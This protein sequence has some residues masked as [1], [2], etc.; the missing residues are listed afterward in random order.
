MSPSRPDP[1]ARRRRR[2]AGR[3]SAHRPPLPL[4]LLDVGQPVAGDGA[5]AQGVAHRAGDGLR[6]RQGERDD[7]RHA[8]RPRL[9]RGRAAAGPPRGFHRRRGGHAPSSPPRRS[10]ST[11][12]SGAS[13]SSEHTEIGELRFNVFELVE[14]LRG[15]GIAHALAHPFSLVAGGLRGE[16]LE[17]L[18]SLFDV[19]E[20]RNGLSCREEDELAEDVVA[21]SAGLRARIGG[22]AGSPQPADRRLRRLQ[23]PHW[24][25]RRHDLHRHPARAGRRDASGRA[26]GR[27]RTAAAA[28][29]ARPPSSRTTEWRS[30]SAAAPAA[31]APCPARRP[32]VRDV[33]DLADLLARP[34]GRRLA[35][36]SLSLSSAAKRL[37][38]GDRGGAARRRRSA[39][40][41]ATS[42][43]TT[44][45][46]GGWI[47][48]QLAGAGRGRLATRR[49]TSSLGDGEHVEI[50]ELARRQEAARGHQRTSRAC[51]PPTSSRPGSTPASDGT[52]MRSRERLAERGLALRPGARPCLAWRCSPT[53][54]TRSTGSPRYCTQLVG[55][56]NAH[57]WPFTLVSAG[58]RATLRAGPRSVPRGRVALARRLSRVPDGSPPRPGDPALVRGQRHRP[59]STPRRRDPWD[60]WPGS[61]PTPSTCRWWAPTTPTSPT[62]GS[63]SPATTC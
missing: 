13:T 45:S 33:A 43:Q 6:P 48:R 29:T 55:H 35:A 9:H 8:H 32:P 51:S 59:S 57:D 41:P 27:P 47:T 28:R 60:S 61:L 15:R 18:L 30:S 54:T 49:C 56:A 38:R 40:S 11:C 63:S 23:R 42:C 7:A 52:H 21:R 22:G 10:T 25:R 17:A 37:R 12:S 16:Q 19:W 39:R 46:S 14:Y 31:V 36:S 1:P 3:R 58:S 20:V 5:W 4:P 62:S 53:P 24:P 2:H 50:G 34:G 26:D 44:S